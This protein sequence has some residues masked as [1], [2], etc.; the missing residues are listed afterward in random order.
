[1]PALALHPPAPACARFAAGRQLFE[2]HAL[3]AWLLTLAGTLVV[4]G[5]IASGRFGYDPVFFRDIGRACGAL[6]LFAPAAR[7][8]GF[9]R[10]AD[11]MEQVLLLL[12]SGVAFAFCSL[13]FAS[14]GAAVA[15]PML[16][17]ADRLLFGVDRTRLIADLHMSD[18]VRQGWGW[19]YNSLG[20]TPTLGFVL[21]GATGRRAEAW[22]LLT[23]IMATA[24]LCIAC[25]ALF[26]AYGTPPY[27][28][29]FERVLA[30]ALDG[31]VR[32]FSANNITGIITFPSMH[33]ADAVILAMAFARLGRWA[34]PLVVLN[35]LMFA[36]ALTVGGHYLVDLVAGGLIGAGVLL[37][38][39]RLHARLGR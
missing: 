35:V 31:S 20:F 34:A 10:I 12:V 37:A 4:A 22:A 24:L 39:W 9:P 5:A 7:W 18:A 36:S 1:M 16:L 29:A 13:V 3:P 32:T 14:A 26:P 19:I 8:I 17:R 38:S 28:Y 33:A 25:L 6:L 30:G 21:L 11:P 2:R 23:A 15:D 27:P